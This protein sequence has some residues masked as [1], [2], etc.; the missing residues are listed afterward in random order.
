MSGKEARERKCY[1]PGFWSGPRSGESPWEGSTVGRERGGLT[2]IYLRPIHQHTKAGLEE[3][4]SFT[5]KQRR[6]N[7]PGYLQLLGMEVSSRG[8]RPLPARRK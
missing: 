8:A 5:S 7:S 1:A 4:F 6:C 3:V 2:T